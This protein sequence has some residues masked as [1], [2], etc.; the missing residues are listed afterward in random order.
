MEFINC[1]NNGGP[2]VVVATGEHFF[3]QDAFSGVVAIAQKVN[4]PEELGTDKATFEIE[5][6][7]QIST[8]TIQRIISKYLSRYMPVKIKYHFNLNKEA[9]TCGLPYILEMRAVKRNK[10]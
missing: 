3:F 8:S 10:K 2:M 1:K 4:I 5:Y 9:G 7:S 6:C